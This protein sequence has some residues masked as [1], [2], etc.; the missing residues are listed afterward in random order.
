MCQHL[1]VSIDN[2]ASEQSIKSSNV[3]RTQYI[4]ALVTTVRISA[5]VL[6]IT[7][8]Q[9]HLSHRV[10]MPHWIVCAIWR[11]MHLG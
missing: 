7:H 2:I 11:A 3:L 6:C 9:Q 1:I 8:L 4:D 5:I 10:V